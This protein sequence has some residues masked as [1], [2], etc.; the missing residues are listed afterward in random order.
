[1]QKEAVSRD[2]LEAAL[3]LTGDM[4]R[5][6]THIEHLVTSVERIEKMVGDD[7]EKRNQIYGRLG[8][9]ETSMSVLAEAKERADRWRFA[10]VAALVGGVGTGLVSIGMHVAE[11]GV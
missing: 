10:L 1:M 11:R 5:V 3:S 6:E 8:V 9:L 4:A 2:D 7:A